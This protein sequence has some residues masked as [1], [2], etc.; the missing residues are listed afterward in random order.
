MTT[1]NCIHTRFFSELIAPALHYCLAC[2]SCITNQWNTTS[3]HKWK[4]LSWVG[5]EP[6]PSA[7]QNC[8]VA[9]R[10]AGRSLAMLTFMGYLPLHVLYMRTL[11]WALCCNILEIALKSLP[12][13]LMTPG[14]RLSRLI[15]AAWPPV[16][17]RSRAAAASRT[18]ILMACGVGSKWRPIARHRSDPDI[19]YRPFP[20]AGPVRQ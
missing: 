15:L 5:F 9:T 20:P 2:R 18:R 11:K 17:T 10:P 14:C 3:I 13:C 8:A 16:S 6:G 1:K 12:L 4:F 7:P 19:L